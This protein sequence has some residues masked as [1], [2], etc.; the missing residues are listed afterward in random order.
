MVTDVDGKEVSYRAD[1]FLVDGDG[2]IIRS[3]EKD[4]ALIA[5]GRWHSVVRPES[6]V[7]YVTRT[8]LETRILKEMRENP[9]QFKADVEFWT[10]ELKRLYEVTL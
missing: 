10:N 4:V 7:S 5:D 8:D 9:E 2:L 1:S 6:V 3:G